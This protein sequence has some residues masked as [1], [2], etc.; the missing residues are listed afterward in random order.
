MAKIN[1]AVK[2]EPIFTHE[3]AKAMHINPYQQLRRSVCSCMLWEKGFYESGESVV[4]RIMGLV[5]LCKPEDVAALALEARVKFKLRHVPL[6]LVRELARMG[7][8]GTADA[9]TVIIQRPDELTEF[10]ALYWKNSKCP[11]SAQVKKGLAKALTKFSEYQLGKYNRDAE[12]RLRD[13]LFL[14]HAKPLNPEQGK[15]WKRLAGGYCDKCWKPLELSDN[16]IRRGLTTCTCP[17]SAEAKLVVP[18]TWETAL[19]SGADKRESWERLL[20]TRKLGGMALLRNLRNMQNEKVNIDMINTAIVGM[21][22]DRVLPFRFISAAKYAPNLEPALE[23]A[24]LR[25]VSEMPKLKGR[26]ALLVDHSGSMQNPLSEKSEITRF[27]AAGALGIMLREICEDEFR[28][29]TF[30]E[31]CMEVAPRRGFAMI[32]AIQKVVNPVWTK[33]GMAVNYVYNA[34]PECERLIVITDEQSAD[35]P[36]NPQGIGYVINVASARNGIGYGPWAHIDGF[37]E[38]VI[39]WIFEHEQL[40]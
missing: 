14:S 3:G 15:L 11:I 39:D 18:D 19:S 9:L 34:F 6:L 33:L 17:D 16:G 1:K 12:I 21:N 29:F 7:Y 38:A 32:D 8:K 23:V 30:S 20:V 25:C 10:L 35:K 40:K 4:S 36:R 37:S 27:D 2:K 5:P 26:T 31:K 28:L 22:T 24:M 13:I